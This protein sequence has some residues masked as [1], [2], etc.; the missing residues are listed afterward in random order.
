MAG[1]RGAG[2]MR[3]KTILF[4][5][6]SG[7]A[8]ANGRRAFERGDQ[9]RTDRGNA[10]RIFDLLAGEVGD[11][12]RIDHLFA[13]RGDVRGRNIE[14]QIRERAGDLGEQAGAVEALHLDHREAV[15]MRI[16]DIGARFDAKGFRAALRRAKGKK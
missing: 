1:A 6:R 7:A 5:C 2:N 13:E 15:R 16:A 8:R 11:V 10:R 14:R 4:G 12:E 9:A 3:I